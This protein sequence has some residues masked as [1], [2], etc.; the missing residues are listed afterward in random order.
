MLDQAEDIAPSNALRFSQ[1][2]SKSTDHRE[3]TTLI[4]ADVPN[5]DDVINVQFTSGTTG[6]PKGAMLT[7]FNIIQNIVLSSQRIFEQYEL[8]DPEWPIVCAPNPLY[9]CFGSVIGSINTVYLQ[10]TMVI[11]EPVFSAPSTLAAIDKYR[12]E[13]DRIRSFEKMIRILFYF[14]QMQLRLWHSH[15]VV[16]HAQR[17]R[18]QVR[19]EKLETR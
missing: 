15:H 9:H 18:Q 8:A 13:F 2:F 16:G 7:H 11:P 6:S 19:F 5:F 3:L 17:G 14:G 12:F 1:L 4:Q 10:G